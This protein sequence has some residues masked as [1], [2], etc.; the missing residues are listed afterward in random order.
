[1][2]TKPARVA[3]QLQPEHA[4]YRKIRDTVAEAE[5][6]GVDV[7]FNWDHFFPLTGDPDGMHF[8]CWTM[9]AA[10]AESTS[11]TEFGPLVSCNGYRNPELLADMARTVDH[12]SDGRLILGV[13]A[14]WC[15]RDFVEYGYDFPPDGKRLD[16]LAQALPRIES[17]MSRMNPTPTRKIPV[18]I[19]GEGEKKTLPLVARHA[20][21]WHSFADPD[22][23]ERKLAVLRGHCTAIGRD[24]AE[25]EVST[26]VWGGP[27]HVGDPDVLGPRLRK[28]GVSLFTVGIGGPDY[29]LGV[30]R[31]WIAWRDRDRAEQG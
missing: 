24:I 12:I 9:L 28:L 22:T 3:L 15:E 23:I 26:G 8:E 17:R 25:I 5:D 21:I 11:R 1:M 6:L 4:N 19:G 10:W 13:G 31:K 30:L 27:S 18:L 20:D 29:D 2:I 16:D 14:G 7:I